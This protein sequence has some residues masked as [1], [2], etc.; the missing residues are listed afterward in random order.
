Q[1]IVLK[2]KAKT[3]YK[4]IPVTYPKQTLGLKL[5][6]IFALIISGMLFV[7]HFDLASNFNQSFFGDAFSGAVISILPVNENPTEEPVE[8]QCYDHTTCLNITTTSC[9]NV[10]CEMVEVC[11]EECVSVCVNE[12]VNDEI[13]EVCT[14]E[15][16]DVC[17]NQTV[18]DEECTDVIEENCTLEEVCEIIDQP[19][20]LGTMDL[21][22]MAAPTVSSVVLNSTNMSTNYTSENLTLYFDV[23]DG[24]GDSVKNITNWFVNG[25]S[26]MVLNMPFEGGSQNGNA[27][28]VPNGAKDYSGYGN[29][30]T[31]VNA[32]WNRTGGYDGKGAYEFDSIDDYIVVGGLSGGAITSHT[33]VAWVKPDDLSGHVLNPAFG[34]F[35]TNTQTRYYFSKSSSPNLQVRWRHSDGSYVSYNLISPGMS[36]DLWHHIAIVYDNETN[37]VS[38]YLDGA[39]GVTNNNMD[40]YS[41]F[42]NFYLGTA[43]A[44]DLMNGT[45]DEVQI[46]NRSLSAEQISALY[47]N[48]T[49]LIVS[50][51]TT[52][53][54]NWSA[55]VTPNDGTEDGT[56][57]ES[58]GVI[59]LNSPASIAL[60]S[61]TNTSAVN[62]NASTDFSWNFI[63]AD[64]DAQSAYQ[65]LIANNSNFNNPEVNITNTTSNAYHTTTLNQTNITYYWKVRI[66]DTDE[67]LGSFSSV[68]QF[69]SNTPPT[70]DT[71]ILNTTN[72]YTNQNLTVYN[73][74]TADVDG[75]SVKNIIN[76][77]VNGTSIMLLNMPFERVNSTT[78]NNAW[79][80]SGLGNNGSVQSAAVWNSTG[81]YDG[82]GA[83][84][85]DGSNQSLI[86]GIPI[87]IVTSDFTYLYWIKINY[88]DLWNYHFTHSFNTFQFICHGN[89]QYF[90]RYKNSTGD[91]VGGYL[92]GN[93]PTD[94]WTHYAFS[95][96]EEGNKL[97]IYENGSLKFEED[98]PDV[99][100]VNGITSPL[101]IGT[102]STVDDF[103][104]FNRTLSAEQISAL[105]QNKTDL[106]VSQET[107][108]GDTWQSC[109]TPNDGFADGVEVCSN[110]ITILNAAPTFNESLT[111]KTVVAEQTFNYDINCFDLDGDDLIYYDNTTLFD[112]DNVTGEITDTPSSGD[113]G[114][115]SINITCGD[116]I[117]N[118]SQAF[119]YNIVAVPAEEET[120]DTTEQD[121]GAVPA[122]DEVVEEAAPAVAA[123][124]TTAEVA[125]AEEVAEAIEAGLLTIDVNVV[126]RDVAKQIKKQI[127]IAN[128]QEIEIT[129]INKGEYAVELT[130]QVEEMFDFTLDNEEQVIKSVQQQVLESLTH[131]LTEDNVQRAPPIIIETVTVEMINDQAETITFTPTI[132]SETVDLILENE[133]QIV[134]TLHSQI[135]S[136]EGGNLSEQQVQELVAE[137]LETIKLI[138]EK[139]VQFLSKGKVLPNLPLIK[140][141]AGGEPTSGI[142]YAGD[143][144]K[145]EY[146]RAQIIDADKIILKPGEKVE[147]KLRVQLGLTVEPRERKITVI[148]ESAEGSSFEKNITVLEEPQLGAIVDLDIINHLLDIY[149]VIPKIEGSFGVED[150]TFELMITGDD[151]KV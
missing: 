41:T 115:Y 54:E 47:Q 70:Q 129:Y 86:R 53:G 33:I 35:Y 113:V 106:I 65:I 64:N 89:N 76:W 98:I 104:I 67:A 91:L 128:I 142:T 108:K 49:D 124:A 31:V 138:E 94:T 51:E 84:Q 73:Q 146:L 10:S 62:P 149:A 2:S 28:G 19:L 81:G 118:T 88:Q 121:S 143:H 126:K 52:K 103:M 151:N 42:N 145:G 137:K 16:A 127:P 111:G 136:E 30:G 57:K 139:N 119:N 20:G 26:I 18:C 21:G 140:P 25:T 13:R 101:G 100:Y 96:D 14:L 117:A 99:I 147:D 6:F 74:S 43:S 87:P 46:F 132:K 102:N 4:Q 29:N 5:M 7:N 45:I 123:E 141:F 63:D 107:T 37:T 112:I 93:C 24:D 78:S 83:Y 133:P 58:N 50:Q 131:P 110:N 11:S 8:E 69:D 36:S 32:T 12:T 72:N 34:M 48:S 109:I 61:P 38:G 40:R 17:V 79:D 90:L 1:K 56:S 71:P 23:A 150:Y 105:Y 3:S 68:F 9:L 55:V 95:Y 75:D 148:Y 44:Y 125:T 60:L 80:Y 15:C 97:S 122:E 77:K 144:T 130:P 59:I 22:I 27:T 135:V 92:G 39:I 82:K 120:S 134:E 114:I 85:F 66:N 116:G